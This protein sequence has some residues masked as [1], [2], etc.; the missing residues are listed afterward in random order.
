MTTHEQFCKTWSPASEARDYEAHDPT[1]DRS[2][3]P[4]V[5]RDELVERGVIR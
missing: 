2:P 1:E 4:S 5:D 3:E